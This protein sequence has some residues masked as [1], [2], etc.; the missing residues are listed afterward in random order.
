MDS[1]PDAAEPLQFDTAA[2]KGAPVIPFPAQR[3]I[4]TAATVQRIAPNADIPR[5]APARPPG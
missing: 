3:P 4:R 1:Q 5:P 2:P